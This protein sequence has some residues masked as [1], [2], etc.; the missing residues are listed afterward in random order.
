MKTMNLR[1]ITKSMS[2]NEMK[3]VKGGLYGYESKVPL[4]GKE[5]GGSSGGICNGGEGTITGYR[6][7]GLE[8]YID[9]RC[10]DGSVICDYPTAFAVCQ[11]GTEVC[12]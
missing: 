4:D 10:S 7:P 2:D 9:I 1:G 8:C 11:R 3:K 6:C 12:R 5:A